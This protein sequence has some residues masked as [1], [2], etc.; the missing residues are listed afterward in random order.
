[1]G[2]EQLESNKPGNFDRLVV[3]RHLQQRETR[4]NNSKQG[5]TS[6]WKVAET[7]DGLSATVIYIIEGKP[8]TRAVQKLG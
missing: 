4:R 1:M 6:S 5:A 3:S 2:G 7:V 8:R